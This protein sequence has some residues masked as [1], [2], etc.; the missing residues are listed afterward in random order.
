M[1]ET[2]PFTLPPLSPTTV[3][4]AL[5]SNP[6]ND[7][8]LI[9]ASLLAAGDVAFQWRQENDQL[10]L[11]GDADE[12]FKGNLAGVQSMEHLNLRLN[13]QDRILR[14]QIFSEI[15][16]QSSSDTATPYANRYECQYLLHASSNPPVWVHERGQAVFDAHGQLQSV[17]GILRNIDDL[18]QQE[19]KLSQFADYDE[20]T[21][22]YN[23]RRLREMLEQAIKYVQHFST[24]GAYLVLGIDQF[25]AINEYYGA[26]VGD[27]LLNRIA[28]RLLHQLRIADLMGRVDG[29]RFGLILYHCTEEEL[30]TAADR[31]IQ[32]VGDEAFQTEHGPIP[33][34]ASIGGV[35]FP[36]HGITAAELMTRAETALLQSKRRGPSSFAK[37]KA[38]NTDKTLHTQNLALQDRV[39]KALQNKQLCLAYQ[40]LVRADS[41]TV[42]SYECLI[43][44]RNTDGSLMPAAEFIPAIE[45][46][47]L[48]RQVDLAVMDMAF[49]DLRAYPDV[50]LAI[51]VSA[52]NIGDGRWLQQILKYLAAEPSLA[53]RLVVELTESAALEDLEQSSHFLNALKKHGCRVALDDFGAGFTSFR[54][55]QYLPVDIM[56]IDRDFVKLLPD[57]AASIRMLTTFIGLAGD[58]SM[59]TVAEG[60]ETIEQ[61][62]LLKELGVSTLQGYYFGKPDIAPS[63]KQEHQ[64]QTL[65]AASA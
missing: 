56:K 39:R 57:D 15:L 4:G 34:S 23:K 14:Q 31:F 5:L 21:G 58:L 35:V 12:L 26:A 16:Y 9:A 3:H 32:V 1:Q 44:M 11:L 50:E 40:P 30:A 38:T 46:M 22:H 62:N 24:T 20:V 54:E 41:H 60:V 13:E 65:A 59:K 51:N 43:R 17:L 49:A 19:A 42:S 37:F 27:K 10:Q 48:V 7:A 52:A 47:G 28:Q 25:S 36:T 63:W 8:E 6:D 61:A 45:K 18:K 53:K 2:H 29:D 33:L 64:Q 55:L